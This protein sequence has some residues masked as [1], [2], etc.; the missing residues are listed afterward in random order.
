MGSSRKSKSTRAK[1]A[2]PHQH[3]PRS[4]IRRKA[5]NRSSAKVREIP[6]GVE[7]EIENQRGVLVTIIT[8]VSCL[9]VVLEH[10]EDSAADQELNPHIEAAIKSA[11]LPDITAM[12]LDRTHAVLDALDSVN[13][14][15]ASKAFKP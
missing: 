5:I 7:N 8:L 2:R 4:R 14:I 10:Q 13:L 3:R 11:S 12:L 15:K 9:H 1:S 6:A